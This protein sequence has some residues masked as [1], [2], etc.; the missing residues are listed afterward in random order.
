MSGQTETIVLH[1]NYDSSPTWR[2]RI[3]LT[4]KGLKFDRKF[5]RFDEPVSE[6]YLKIN[7]LGQ[8]PAL[9][10]N[11]DVITQSLAIIDYLDEKC[12]Q[13]KLIPTDLMK[14]AKAKQ[15]AEIVNSGNAG[16]SV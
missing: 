3:A 11:G 12:P 9:E 4:L 5:Y 10:I 15:I 13:P 8:I 6:A 16:A 1:T 14:R 7:P 2:V